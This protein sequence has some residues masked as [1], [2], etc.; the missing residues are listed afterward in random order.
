MPAVKPRG[1]Q[2]RAYDQ[3]ALEELL[4]V[5]LFTLMADGTA[6][7][8][9]S[10]ERIVATAG[11]ARSTFYT[12]YDDKA[13]ML[14]AL[15]AHTLIRL[16]EGPRGWISKGSEARR[17][18]IARGLRELLDTFL[19]NEVVMRAVAEASGYDPSV[20]E[21]YIGG[22]EDYARAL[23]RFIRAGHK[24]GRMR[25]VPPVETATAL[26]W[27]TER[28]VSRVAPGTPEARLNALAEAM[29]EIFWRTLFED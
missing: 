9:L 15:S 18:D 25:D 7:G 11:V 3:E 19:E 16:Y 4:R 8:D 12:Y 10:V 27:M 6:F 17:S 21:A 13:A 28:T 20:R 26:A 5:A 1:Q 29:T 2:G 24:A 23:A 22:V 14:R